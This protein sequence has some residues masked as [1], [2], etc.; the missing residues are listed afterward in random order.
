[1]LMLTRSQ[2]LH[3]CHA[4]ARGRT[5]PDPVI[6]RRITRWRWVRSAHMS[7]KERR[8]RLESCAATR[9]LI[10]YAAAEEYV[11]AQVRCNAGC[12]W[13][14]CEKNRQ[15][16]ERVC[17]GRLI[18]EMIHS[19]GLARDVAEMKEIVFLVR[20][21]PRP[22]ATRTLIVAEMTHTTSLQGGED[23]S[24]L[25]TVESAA[26]TDQSCS[27]SRLQA[28]AWPLRGTCFR[29]R[30]RVSQKALEADNHRGI[31]LC[32]VRNKQQRHCLRGAESSPRT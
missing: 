21:G 5:R 28:W 24:A 8:L 1:M 9:E 26:R 7:Q 30:H 15:G 16:G 29:L 12:R 23:L 13:Q 25:S 10:D 19:A 20:R 27:F 6:C 22:F 18:D 11:A 14:T 17:K 4:W 2:R 32:A 31:T 3:T